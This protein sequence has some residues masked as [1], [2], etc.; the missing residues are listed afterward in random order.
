MA[1][2]GNLRLGLSS[3]SLLFLLNQAP[4]SLMNV[5]PQAHIYDSIQC[6]AILKPSCPTTSQTSP[7]HPIRH[8]HK[9]TPPRNHTC[10]LPARHPQCLCI[11]RVL[12]RP[13]RLEM[14]Q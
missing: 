1:E 14:G 13:W 11:R 6:G 8:H 7:T 12:D 4:T 9:S 5:L 10:E 3:A 2:H